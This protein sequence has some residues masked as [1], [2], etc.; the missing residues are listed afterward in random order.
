MNRVSRLATIAFAAFA[1][2]AFPLTAASVTTTPATAPTP[3]PNQRVTYTYKT[4]LDPVRVGPGPIG[5]LNENFGTLT[6]TFN[7]DKIIQGTY[8]PDFGNFTTVTG[9]LT[10]GRNLWLDIGGT[11][12]TGRFTRHGFAASSALTPAGMTWRLYGYFQH[13]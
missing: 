9:G 5:D 1:T 4:F 11:H 3:P 10:G 6:L 13:L 7:P 8:K 12:Y 2:L